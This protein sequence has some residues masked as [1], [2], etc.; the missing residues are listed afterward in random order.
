MQVAE[1][2]RRQVVHYQ[3]DLLWQRLQLV[4]LGAYQLEHVRI[5]LVRHDAA[6]RRAF[7]RQTDEAEVLAVEQAGIEGHLG[8]RAGD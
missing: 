2:S 1:I 5:L 7:F 3:R 4:A 6:A 8:Q